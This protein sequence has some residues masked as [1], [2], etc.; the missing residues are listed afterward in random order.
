MSEIIKETMDEVWQIR[1]GTEL[2][3]GGRKNPDNFHH[4][5]KWGFTIY[6]TYY[7][8][9]SD[10]HWKTLL[11]SLRH[12][13]KLAFGAFEDDG[14]TDQDDMRRVQEL[15]HLDHRDD[16]S[17]LDGLDVRGLREFC[18]AEKLQETE[19]VEK[20]NRKLRVSTRPPENRAM[21]DYLFDYV[22]LADEAVLKN[23]ENGEFIVKAVS[24]SWD[25]HSGWGWVRIPTGYLLDLWTFLMW[26]KYR[27]EFCISFRG[28]EAELANSIWP[29]DVGLDG[30]GRYSEIRRRK[31]YS[32]QQDDMY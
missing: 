27:T 32:N 11:Y 18:N 29:G 14:E 16:P 28:S 2:A 6:R 7:G 20:A 17:K 31:F 12:Q 3:P 21:A 15:F 26:N 1:R 30:T 10:K 24:L 9:E 22:L 25:G 8:K 23:V 5:R 4:Y 13:T 19:V